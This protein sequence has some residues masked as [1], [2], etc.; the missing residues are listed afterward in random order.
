MP[1]A[2]RYCTCVGRKPLILLGA[3]DTTGQRGWADFLV[4]ASSFNPSL[5]Y[6]SHP[7]YIIEIDDTVH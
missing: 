3:R 4:A 2:L 6:F 1:N 5:V 7:D